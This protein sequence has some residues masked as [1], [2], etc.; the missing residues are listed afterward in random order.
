MHLLTTHKPD[1]CE[2]VVVVKAVC[3]CCG[4]RYLKCVRTTASD[5]F[6][7]VLSYERQHGFLSYQQEYEVGAGPKTGLTG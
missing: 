2:I 7:G 3:L 4:C 5:G 6:P 1:V